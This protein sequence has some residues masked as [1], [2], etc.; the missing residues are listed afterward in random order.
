LKKFKI[1][2]E[3][4]LCSPLAWQF[5]TGTTKKERR[6]RTS[7][8]AWDLAQEVAGITSWFGT[9]WSEELKLFPHPRKH[10]TDSSTKRDC[11]KGE[12]K[13]SAGRVVEKI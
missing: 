12:G 10:D 3:D 13:R 7:T 1:E 5:S 6:D 11:G 8:E 9:R 4:N 2:K